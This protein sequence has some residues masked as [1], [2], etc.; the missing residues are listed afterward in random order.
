MAWKERV[1]TIPAG[2]IQD[3]ENLLALRINGAGVKAGVGR[4]DTP[5]QMKRLEDVGAYLPLDSS[6]TLTGC[7]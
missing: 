6:D 5:A 1:Y 7:M 3:G 2:V 4:F